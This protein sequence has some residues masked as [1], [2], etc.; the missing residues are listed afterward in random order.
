[1]VS[2]PPPPHVPA[3]SADA[4]L[5]P[6]FIP[7]ISQAEM[8]SFL[9]SVSE[10][11]SGDSGPTKCVGP[12]PAL[13]L[14]HVQPIQHIQW[15]LSMANL[16]MMGSLNLNILPIRSAPIQPPPSHPLLTP[17]F[18]TL[19]CV[20]RVIQISSNVS[21]HT[22]KFVVNFHIICTVTYCESSYIPWPWKVRKVGSGYK[23]Y[24]QTHCF[25]LN[26][27]RLTLR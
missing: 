25:P 22:Q 26:A 2:P 20:F 13:Y 8:L 5:L 12:V 16:S 4:I 11:R 24:F 9:F 23:S 1:M 15:S 18:F 21:T 6:I 7:T 17:S 27:T 14:Y 3:P 19:V 10:Q